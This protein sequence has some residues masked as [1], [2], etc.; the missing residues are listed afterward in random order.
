MWGI[1]ILSSKR[2]ACIGTPMVNYWSYSP[3]KKC[4]NAWERWPN[5]RCL[6]PL[7]GWIDDKHTDAFNLEFT[8][9]SQGS[10]ASWAGE[11]TD[12]L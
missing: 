7:L 10:I 6:E 4:I 2:Q 5:I 8:E 9:N 11:T 3:E 12:P 1:P